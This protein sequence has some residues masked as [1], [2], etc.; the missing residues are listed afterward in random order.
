MQQYFVR[1][2]LTSQSTMV[3]D[4][5]QSH[6]L[7]VV[8]RMKVGSYVHVVD[9][10]QQTYLVALTHL[11]E[12]VTGHIES[13]ITQERELPVQI[14]LIQGLV[15]GDKWDWILQKTSELGV[16]RIV[17]L[18]SKRSVVKLLG[19]KNDKKI[20]R[21]NK[22]TLEACEQ[23]KR[24]ALVEVCEPISLK[25]VKHYLGQLNL[26]AY[27]DT[28]FKALPLKKRLD[29][30]HVN[31]I[32]IVVG[33]EGGFD[34]SEISELEAMGFLQVSLGKR[35]LRAETASIAMVNTIGWYFENKE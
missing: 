31:E 3:F 26:V 17:P 7:R 24:N 28:D 9:A 20:T 12:E 6:H 1:D 10:N 8:L 35:I 22:I 32:T 18:Q 21:W 14:T 11:D 29:A 19:E 15:K 13:N 23:S 27:E 34:A 5:E 33:P 25:G 4:R 2:V 16:V 30:H